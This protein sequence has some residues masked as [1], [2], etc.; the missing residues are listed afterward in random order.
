MNTER[1][2]QS[3]SKQPFP[4]EFNYFFNFYWAKGKL[5]SKVLLSRVSIEIEPRTKETIRL[6][7]FSNS[8]SV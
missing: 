3:L 1:V 4:H 7:I 2:A 6:M 5:R 8:F